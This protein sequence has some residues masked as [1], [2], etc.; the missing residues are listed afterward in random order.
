MGYVTKNL[1]SDEHVVYTAKVHWIVFLTPIVS[2]IIVASSFGYL[3][4]SDG[5]NSDEF[6][7]LFFLIMGITFLIWFAVSFIKAFTVW[8]GT[9]LAVTSKR[10]IAKTGLIQRNTV[11]LNHSKVESFS[12]HQSILGRILGYGDVVVNGT[13]GIGTPINRVS[14]PIQFRKEAMQVVG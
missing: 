10:V 13:G 7:V 3:V 1:I 9:E 11:E 8:G 2:L 4:L 12:V 6:T 5:G 14:K